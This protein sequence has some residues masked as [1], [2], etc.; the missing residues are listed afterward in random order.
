MGTLNHH[1]IASL[2]IITNAIAEFVANDFANPA[3]KPG[4]ADM[5]ISAETGSEAEVFSFEFLFSGI[6]EKIFG[7]RAK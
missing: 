6:P 7:P 2:N 3:N 4:I 1:C 5:V